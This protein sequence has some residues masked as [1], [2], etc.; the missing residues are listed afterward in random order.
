MTKKEVAEQVA[1]RI[2][3]ISGV[4]VAYVDDYNQHGSF[5]V[6]VCL[7]LDKNHKPISKSFNMM[8]IRGGIRK[9]LNETKQISKFGMSIETPQRKYY[10]SYGQSYFDGYERNYIMIDFTVV[11]QEEQVT[12]QELLA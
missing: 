2:S 3:K 7:N 8:A 10:R 11:L 12:V 6:V 4:N 1:K 5:Q 9:I